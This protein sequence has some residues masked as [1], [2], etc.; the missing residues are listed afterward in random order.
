M[1][2]MIP[3]LKNDYNLNTLLGVCA[4]SFSAVW[5]LL[6]LYILVVD[7]VVGEGSE[8]LFLLAFVAIGLAGLVVGSGMLMRKAWAPL[9]GQ[10]ALIIA[11]ATWVAL[12]S[13]TLTTS[14]SYESWA[15]SI[16]IALMG[17]IIILFGIFILGNPVILRY[18]S[19][20]FTF[21]G[22]HPDILDDI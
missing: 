3:M 12:W 2:K 13:I 20:K 21:A 1:Q 22:K 16:G 9:M 15:A 7:H 4:T 14:F 11:L 6:C 19:D 18:Y 17:D 10:V 8:A 5:F